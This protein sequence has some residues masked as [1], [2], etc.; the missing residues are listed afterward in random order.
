MATVS[1]RSTQELNPWVLSVYKWGLM[2]CLWSGPPGF[3][4]WTSVATAFRSW[5]AVEY[6]LVLSLWWLLI[7]MFAVL[8]HW[9]VGIL[10]ADRTSM[11]IWTTAE[12]RVRLLQ[13]KTGLS[14]P[15]PP[16]PPHTPMIYYWPFQGDALWFI[17]IVNVRPLS[18]CLWLY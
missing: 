8:I 10:H 14:A 6:S 7:Y 16:H 15:P 12:P 5:F 9:W 2:I 18:V 3:I 17:L 4:C 11:C 13:R 1:H